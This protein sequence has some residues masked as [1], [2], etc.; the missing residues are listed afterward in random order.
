[1]QRIQADDLVRLAAVATAHGVR[2]ALKL[3]CFTEDP[4]SVGD[5]GPLFDSGG[6]RLF[7]I[8]VIGP[9]KGGVVVEAEGIR[10]RNAAEA[11]RGRELFV[12][13]GRLPQTDE[14]EFYEGDLV[15]LSV[16]GPDGGTVGR[17]TAL[18]DFGAGEILVYE[19][20]EGRET[21]LPFTE[22]HVPA[23]DLVAGT[24]TI[25]ETVLV[26]AS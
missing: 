17:V 6:Q 19:D 12:P 5:Y 4:Q 23:I 20:A 21:M 2:G 15:G 24:V 16:L 18:Q 11:L 22:R 1:M 10:D 25:A 3:R 14:N 7:E 26:E 13:R 9:V 8:R